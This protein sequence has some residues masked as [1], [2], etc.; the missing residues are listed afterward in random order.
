MRTSQRCTRRSA[1][2]VASVRPSG[3]NATVQ[4]RTYPSW[5]ATVST[6]SVATRSPRATSQISASPPPSTG[7]SPRHP[8]IEDD[9]VG[10]E[11]PLE[12]A[13]SAAELTLHGSSGNVERRRI[14]QDEEEPE[15]NSIEAVGPFARDWQYCGR[16]VL[17]RRH[18]GAIISNDSF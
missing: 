7:L 12:A 5:P 3:L 18:D 17:Q 4:P 11:D 6:L 14:Q 15:A 1:P 16:H 2:P 13:Q 10:V 8:L 9:A